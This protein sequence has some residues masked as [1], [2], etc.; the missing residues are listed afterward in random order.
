[1][2]TNAIVSIFDGDGLQ[3]FGYDISQD[4][5]PLFKVLYLNP[6]YYVQA[7]SGVRDFLPFPVVGY[8]VCKF[9]PAITDVIG[10]PDSLEDNFDVL[11]WVSER[12]KLLKLDKQSLV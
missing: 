6:N 1:M 11:K 5:I 3:A 4:D 10:L 9:S 12:R 2:S 8:R 7:L